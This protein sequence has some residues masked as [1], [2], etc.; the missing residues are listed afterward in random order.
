MRKILFIS[1]HLDDAVFSCAVRILREVEAGSSVVVATV[2]S[3]GRGP[4]ST[5]R[6]YA[7]RRQED[8]R[9]L[10]LLGAKPLWIGL[11]DAPSRNPFYNSFSRIVL[12]TAPAD[13]D[14][15]QIVRTRI[16]GLLDDL[17]PEAVYL[18]L[19]VGTHIDHRL[20]FAAGAGLPVPCQR[21][22]YE[23][24]PYASVRFSTAMRLQ[25]LRANSHGCDGGD[26]SMTQDSE[27]QSQFLKHFRAA[28]YVR[29]YLPPGK[30]RR[31]CETLLCKKLRATAEPT[32][33]LESEIGLASPS[34]KLRI[35]NTIYAY[36]SQASMFLGARKDF[37]A[38]CGRHARSLGLDCWRAERF[39]KPFGDKKADSW[40]REIHAQ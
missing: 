7:A 6:E 36:C 24:Q 18:P 10:A 13:V 19:G 40:A 29:R 3:R 4:A 15:I 2:F 25:D 17:K 12:G 32:I 33:R 21:F 16:K 38:A 14:H 28:P 39:W 37:V 35:I 34:D 20:V 8:R 27:I 9:A 30:E 23:D 1:P 5:L 11:L 26:C 31:E 22:Y